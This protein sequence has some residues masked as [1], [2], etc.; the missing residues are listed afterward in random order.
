MP[1]PNP[2]KARLAKACKQQPGDIDEFRRRTWAVL[3]LAYDDCAVEDIDGRRRAVLAY[4]QLASVYRQLLESSEITVLAERLAALE[5][6]ASVEESSNG[7]HQGR[8]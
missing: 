5:A 7:Y 3:C 1:N 2:W 6:S 4:G 8:H